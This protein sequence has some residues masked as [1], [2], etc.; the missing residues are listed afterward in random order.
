[1]KLTN[2]HSEPS[3]RGLRC[4]PRRTLDEHRPKRCSRL[5][6][7][8]STSLPPSRPGAPEPRGEARHGR[9][10]AALPVLAHSSPS[11][12][13]LVPLDAPMRAWARPDKAPAPP[14]LLAPNRLVA[15]RTPARSPSAT[16]RPWLKRT[17]RRACA[18]QPEANRRVWSRVVTIERHT[19]GSSTSIQERTAYETGGRTMRRTHSAGDPPHVRRNAPDRCVNTPSPW[20]VA[21]VALRALSDGDDRPSRSGLSAL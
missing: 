15:A 13:F 21:A 17:H 5:S 18:L 11:G 20:R 2:E 4:P 3:E 8:T 1:M 7:P 14:A 19:F 16:P 10:S 6:T 9:E 12:S